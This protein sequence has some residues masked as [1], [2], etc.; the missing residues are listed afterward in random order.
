MLN[1]T[2]QVHS[3]VA[4]GVIALAGC[5]E[6]LD[7]TNPTVIDVDQI[8][9]VADAATL[10]N[11]AQQNFADAYGWMIVYSSWFVGETDVSETFP[12][13]NEFG[14]RAIVIQNGSLNT[15]VWFPL[16]RTVASTYLVLEAALPN[17]GTDLN[18][19]RA[20]L[21]LGYA[22]LFRAEHFC[23]G[24]VRA[25]P[26]LTTAAMLDSAVAH[27]SAAVTVGAAAGDTTTGRRLARAALVGR[28]RAHLQAGNLAQAVADAD[29]VPVGFTFEL[30]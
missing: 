8:D 14:R 29:A 7:V 28:A 6:W 20:H 30:P 16:S 12:T 1:L 24:T 4:A 19:A 25:G 3:A 21:W 5:A 27:L 10:A 2:K 26:E 23:R 22:F 11:S 13:R 17:P 15:D 18:V 9:P